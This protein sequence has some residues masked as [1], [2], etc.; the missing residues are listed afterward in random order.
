MSL[1]YSVVIAVDRTDKPLPVLEGLKKL[2]VS[3][4]PREVFA[5][6]GKN[7]SLQRNL[8]VKNCKTPIVYFLDDDSFVI[9]G[10]VK[11]LLGH[12]ENARVAVA[13]GPNL[14]PPDAI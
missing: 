1:P 2:P 9:P 3:E 14:V 11:Y 13:G 7:P 4:R 12:F 5:C 8:G 6:V 10:T